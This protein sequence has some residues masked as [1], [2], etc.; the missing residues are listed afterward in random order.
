MKAILKVSG[1]TA[2][3]TNLGLSLDI[4]VPLTV[5]FVFFFFVWRSRRSMG[6]QVIIN[7]FPRVSQTM[8]MARTIGDGPR[9]KLVTQPSHVHFKSIQLT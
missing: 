8:I 3:G 6:S 1:C 9:G 4:R 7:D 2:N 5:P